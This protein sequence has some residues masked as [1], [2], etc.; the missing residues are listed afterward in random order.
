MRTMRTLRIEGCP[1]ETENR[2]G[3]GSPAGAAR[4][5]VLLRHV[6]DE[7]GA[8]IEPARF[9]ACVVVLGPLFT[10]A[11]RAEPRRRDATSGEVIAHRVRAMDA[12]RHVVF[13]RADV[14]GV[15]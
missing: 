12:K 8:A 9:L 7:G 1:P 14:A 4:W 2:R 10:V 5:I 15:A 3:P 11:H 13:G 6:H